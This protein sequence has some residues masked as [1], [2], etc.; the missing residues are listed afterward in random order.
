MVS[1]RLVKSC[2]SADGKKAIKQLTFEQVKT[3]FLA[4]VDAAIRQ[5]LKIE[6]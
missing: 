2:K 5:K 1:P 6:N 4:L 3:S